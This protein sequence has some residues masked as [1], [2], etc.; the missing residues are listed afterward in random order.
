MDFPFK[1]SINGALEVL[2]N[3]ISEGIIL[4]NDPG[5]IFWCNR[6][7]GQIIGKDTKSLIGCNIKKV[8]PFVEFNQE[9]S[10]AAVDDND[11]EKILEIKLMVLDGESDPIV[12]A[13]V[14]KDITSAKKNEIEL[15]EV[16]QKND[17][18]EDILNSLD[19]GVQVVNEKGIVTFYNPVQERLDN[20]KKENVI[21][22]HMTEIY[23]LDDESSF[24]LRVLKTGKSIDD[25]QAYVTASRKLVNIISTAVPFYRDNKIVGAVAIT[26]D[27][28]SMW[29]FSKRVLALNAEIQGKKIK[30]KKNFFPSKKLYA[31]KDIIGL[32]LQ[33]CNAKV[34]AQ[35]AANSPSPVLIYGETGTGKELFAQSIHDASNRREKP[36]IA[37]N[38]AAIPEN[39]LEGILF[40]TVPG[41]F[42]GAVDRPG[43]FEQA[44]GGTVFLDEINS[45]PLSLQ[46]KLLRVIQ[47]GVVRRV[48][49]IQDY[50][51]DIRII[52]SSNEKPMEAIYKKT[53]RS[54]LFYRIGVVY[55]SIPSLRERK[56]DLLLLVDFFINE[57][58]KKFN[59]EVNGISPEVEAVFFKYDWPGN[60]R[61]LEHVIECAMN[62]INT[63][64][65]ILIE[66]L[67][68]YIKNDFFQENS[69]KPVMIETKI[70]SYHN[71]L[72]N[73]EINKILSALKKADGNISKAAKDLLMT[74]QCLQYKMKKFQISIHK[75]INNPTKGQG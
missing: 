75:N 32:N 16:K 56:D 55:I 2:I 11:K 62:T 31:F 12:K 26:K 20:M 48:G 6:S 37:I 40:G 38:C 22:K 27:F 10:N 50:I 24:L 66:H 14:L 42:T 69:N 21:G 53:L 49:G 54:D 60:V 64:T 33:L 74:R 45:M 29:E 19:H 25:R 52:S 5:A 63:E 13:M 36:F 73:F 17:N 67:P 65:Q 51:I 15:K 8:C 59:K 30:N 4:Y 70:G 44:S 41:A 7:A 35:K 43:L 68:E 1:K 47:E 9:I 39:L 58:N 46:A 72:E 28:D 61:Q 18:Y 71:D 57:K 34:L 23:K 3:S